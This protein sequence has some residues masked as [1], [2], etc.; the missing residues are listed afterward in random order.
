MS[1]RGRVTLIAAVMAAIVLIPT[2]IAVVTVVRVV[3]ATN[4][5][6]ETRAAGEAVV[7]R[8]RGGHVSGTLPL[9]DP[10]VD[11][12]QVVAPD[13]AVL[14]SSNAAKGLARLSEVWPAPRHPIVDT[15][16][17]S[18]PRCV[19]LSAIR[20]SGA[21]DSP[22]VYAAK[23]TPVVLASD[24][25]ELGVTI[26][27][28]LLVALVAWMTW[29]VCGR[30]LRPVAAMRAELDEINAVDLSRRV[31]VPPGDDEVAQ[32]ARSINGTL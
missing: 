25:L 13:G 19:H 20:V 12:L 28:A 24:S 22:V 15:T 32:L 21:A 31:I 4:L 8:V 17:C 16:S 7:E 5:W 10:S 14:A 30:A 3:L 9:S 27:T 2:G 6:Q 1:L 11:M 29:V 23:A 26:E 18:A